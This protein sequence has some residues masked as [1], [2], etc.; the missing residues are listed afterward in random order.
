[1][2]NSVSCLLTLVCVVL[3]PL[4]SMAVTLPPCTESWQ[5]AQGYTFNLDPKTG[6]KVNIMLNIWA[7]VDTNLNIMLNIWATVDTYLFAAFVFTVA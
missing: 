1:M 7:T 3:R 5:Q 4:T 2:M 6:H